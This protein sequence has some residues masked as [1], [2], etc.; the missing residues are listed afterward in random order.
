MLGCALRVIL[1]WYPPAQGLQHRHRGQLALA[2]HGRADLFT[3][4]HMHVSPAHA[5]HLD[6]VMRVVW[7]SAWQNAEVLPSQPQSGIPVAAG[8]LY[9][10][11]CITELIFENMKSGF[12]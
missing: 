11:T 8:R 4:V 1:S 2:R 7:R 12:W 3:C 6:G 10:V 5:D 9:P